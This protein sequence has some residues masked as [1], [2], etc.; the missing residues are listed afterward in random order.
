MGKSERNALIPYYEFII[1]TSSRPFTV[2]VL[3]L[4]V[5]MVVVVVV[6]GG[7]TY[8]TLPLP[9]E[10]AGVKLLRDGPLAKASFFCCV[11][12]LT[13]QKMTNIYQDHFERSG[14]RPE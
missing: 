5:V 13:L 9:M 4:V 6:V 2:V 11:F 12:V 8:R 7:T 10:G 14:P 1:L 3:V